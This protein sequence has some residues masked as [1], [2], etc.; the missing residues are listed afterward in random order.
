MD[1]RTQESLAAGQACLEA[2][3]YYL[4]LG[5]SVLPLCAPDHV[6]IRT[7]APRHSKSCQ[8]PGKVPW[9]L[10]KEFQDRLPTEQEVKDWFAKYPISN[11]GMALGPVSGVI[12][13]DVEGLAGEQLLRERSGG[14][15]PP[16]LEFRSGRRDGTGRGVLY[17]IPPGAVLRTTI[18]RAGVKS[19]LRFQARGAQTVLPPSR[20]PDGDLY[21]W[22]P[23]HAPPE[24]KIALAPDWLVA[25]LRAEGGVSRPETKAKTRE[26][27]EEVF[28]GVSEGQ[29]NTN[30]TSILGGLFRN[31]SDLSD[32]A[33]ATLRMT[34]HALNGRF[35]EPL[36]DPE[37][38]TIVSS[39]QR[40]EK[41]RRERE[42]DGALNQMIARQIDASC[43]PQP[44][45]EPAD[46]GSNGHGKCLE[47]FD[48]PWQLKIRRSEPIKNFLRAPLWSG[49]PQVRDR[50][51][52]I[53]LPTRDLCHWSRIVVAV[54]EQANWRIP[55][56]LKDWPNIL[57]R[58]YENAIYEEAPDE[59]KRTLATLHFLWEELRQARQVRKE[60]D[61]VT[62]R[63]GS[64]DPEILDDGTTIVKLSWLTSQSQRQ[65]DPFSSCE[66]VEA[67]E[68]AGMTMRVLGAKRKRSRWWILSNSGMDS[69]TDIV[70]PDDQDQPQSCAPCA[71]CAPV[72]A[73]DL[74]GAH[75]LSA[76]LFDD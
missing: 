36:A 1:A 31:L 18:E 64:G 9:I 68:K 13:I 26:E 57:N 25:E 44:A 4:S 47:I 45:P 67:M 48:P 12:R 5:W 51:G 39:V 60:D 35:E 55:D 23:G 19:E 53:W 7:V 62:T 42:H 3:L 46:G 29:R 6:G 10:W 63:Y 8:S 73:Q 17:A 32:G 43:P 40:M 59:T 65:P 11:L 16:T 72:C 70:L 61:G 37:V 50:G 69:L 27:W 30:L 22:T 33:V 38:E 24:R 76:E 75:H 15:L 54:A 66:V 21:V 41:A 56:K 2:A 58:L 49:R 34:A 14:D 74:E 20:H 71:P 52:Y 28:A